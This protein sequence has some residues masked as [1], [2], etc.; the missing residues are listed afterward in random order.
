MNT[1]LQIIVILIIPVSMIISGIKNGGWKDLY[2][3]F[4]KG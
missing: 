3:R 1:V 2:S 4:K